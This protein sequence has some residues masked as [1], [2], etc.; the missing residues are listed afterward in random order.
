MKFLLLALA[1][2]LLPATAQ[3]ASRTWTSRDGRTLDAKLLSADGVQ[4]TVMTPDARV[5]N[6]PLESLSDA[7]QAYVRQTRSLPTP[8]TAATPAAQPRKTGW[9]EDDASA[10]ADA[11]SHNLP[12][13]I[14]FTGSDW[15]PPCMRLEKEVFSK[16]AFKS[17]ADEQLVL[18]K[19]DFPRR[20]K[21]PKDIQ[22]ANQALA[23]KYGIRGYPTMVL[24]D[25]NG[26]KVDQFGYG[27]QNAAA[28]VDML[29]GKL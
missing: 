3:E 5:L 19:A 2:A 21:L 27:G 29:K 17:F 12:T 10:A 14:L 26:K 1:L 11:K 16:S 20:K 18:R 6:L 13:L 8:Q 15:C 9:I 24:L 25:A 4:A 28:F 23:R 22:E 7:D